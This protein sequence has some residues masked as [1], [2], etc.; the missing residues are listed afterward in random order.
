MFRRSF[1]LFL[2]PI[3]IGNARAAV[4]LTPVVTDVV[5]DGSKYREA[6]FK[7]PEGKLTFVLPPGWTISGQKDRAQL[8]SP[9]K[10]SDALIEA[11]PMQKPEALDEAVITKFK[12]QVLAALPPGSAKVK[13]VAE[14]Q[15]S[16]M[17]G[18]YPSFEFVVSYDLWG[19]SYQ[20]SVVLANGPQDRLTFR[21]TCAQADFIVLNTNFRRSL[22]T[23]RA[24]ATNQPPKGAIA[25]AGTPQQT[26]N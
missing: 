18:G 26:A 25:A 13:T 6:S 19:K 16:I 1:L 2:F 8:A 9:D 22:M 24:V 20:R 21:F 14:A 3:L 5:E 7:T 15:N 23:W 11:I 12:Q 17:P 4:D 10:L